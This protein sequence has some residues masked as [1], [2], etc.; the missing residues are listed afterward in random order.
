MHQGDGANVVMTDSGPVFQGFRKPVVGQVSN[1]SFDERQVGNLS[2]GAPED[3]PVPYL[4]G[5]KG[6]VT[7]HT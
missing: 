7:R 6:D 2:C 4:K 5:H 1:L 3:A